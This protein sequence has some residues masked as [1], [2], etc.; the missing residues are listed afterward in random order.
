MKTTTPH[1][2]RLVGWARPARHSLTPRPCASRTLEVEP[3]RTRAR[4]VEGTRRR[5]LDEEHEHEVELCRLDLTEC[6]VGPLVVVFVFEGVE[7]PLLAGEARSRWPSRFRFQRPMHSFVPAILFRV[8]RQDSLGKNP[9][10]DPPNRK[11]RKPTGGHGSEGWPVVC[12]DN[13]WQTKL[14]KRVIETL[15]HGRMQGLPQA[16][17][18]QQKPAVAVRDRQRMAVVPSNEKIPL[19]SAHQTESGPSKSLSFGP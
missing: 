14:A 1:L 10:L 3:H 19:K 9:E 17:A 13:V 11:P 12:S 15:L 8:A 5:A 7:Y 6:F 4:L 2:G 16:R 18:P